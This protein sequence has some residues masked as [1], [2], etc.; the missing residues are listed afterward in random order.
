MKGLRT[1]LA[2]AIGGL[3]LGGCGQ[4]SGEPK[5]VPKEGLAFSAAPRTLSSGNAAR[6]TSMIGVSPSGTHAFAWVEL[7]DGSE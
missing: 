1:F 4:I 2:V 6:V 3:L 7:A 5:S